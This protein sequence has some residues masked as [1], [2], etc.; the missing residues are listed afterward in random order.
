MMTKRLLALF[1]ALFML[2]AAGCASSL[3]AETDPGPSQTLEVK[4]E[5]K[6]AEEERILPDPE[7]AV[8]EIP[9][10]G[11]GLNGWALTDF[12]IV[13]SETQPD[14]T[15]RAAEWLRDT[16]QA[17]TGVE[18]KITTTEKQKEPLAHEIV[19]GETDREI[20]KALDAKS[21]GL[22]CSY[23][24]RRGHVAMEGNAFAVAAA[25]YRFAEDY[26]SGKNVPAEITVAQP[27]T[28]AP[29]NFILLIG[30]GMG[31]NQT[32]LFE[33]YKDKRIV[34]YTDGEESFYGLLFPN[35]GLAVTNNVKGT[36]TDS[37]ASATALA[38]GYKTANAR[39]GR[40]ADDADL[41]S[42]TELAASRGMATAV[43]STEV[44]TGATPSAF[45]AHASDRDET[46]AILASQKSVAAKCG[47]VISCD[48]NVYTAKELVALEDAVRQNLQTLFAD[49]EGSFMMFEEAYI[50]KHCHN[51]ELNEAFKALARFDQVIGLVM[52]E[53]FYHPE[54]VVVITADHETGGLVYRGQGK[55]NFSDDSH[56]S[57][58]VPVFAYGQGTE[59]F[60]GKTV[61]NVQ[62]PKTLAKMF[63]ASLA[64][65]TD[66]TYP[67]L[68]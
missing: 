27:I 16:I 17:K 63:G 56:T 23:L 48:Y 6:T 13:Y 68:F 52:E 64:A 67:P 31:Q 39:I 54:T 42:I 38:T 60:N 58:K 65:D 55:F 34:D 8:A 20:S 28:A 66:A 22:E 4:T 7:G 45:S 3:P 29:K 57:A 51:N 25:A 9:V 49:P 32:K 5:E 53:A 11:A 14:Y 19:V 47:T 18:L 41:L 12:T 50:D 62:I 10:E 43:M 26:L 35:K 1:I 21:E 2:F 24:A 59:V 61:E 30:D 37:A 46:E 36:T 15:V 33:A 40:S 44:S